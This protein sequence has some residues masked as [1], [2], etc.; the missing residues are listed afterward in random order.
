[1]TNNEGGG[2]I[3]KPSNLGVPALLTI[4]EAAD[5]LRVTPRTIKKLIAA[6]ELP[7]VWV[8]L[9]ETRRSKR[10]EPD[11]LREFIERRRVLAA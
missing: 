2:A 3:R 10:I 9:G 11:A 4:G 7:V 6:N 8:T 5:V 1:M